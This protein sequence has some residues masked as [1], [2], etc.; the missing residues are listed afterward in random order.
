MAIDLTT[1]D[2]HRNAACKGVGHNLFYG[3]DHERGTVKAVREKKA[4]ELCW[5]CPVR[6]RCLDSAIER[7]DKYGVQG[8]LDEDERALERRRRMRRVNAA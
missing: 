7:G 4:K 6:V 2:W 1:Y 8:G 5:A 3:S